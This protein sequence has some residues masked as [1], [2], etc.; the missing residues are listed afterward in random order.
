MLSNLRILISIVT[1]VMEIHTQARDEG[2]DDS[3]RKVESKKQL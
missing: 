2:R 1:G 3:L